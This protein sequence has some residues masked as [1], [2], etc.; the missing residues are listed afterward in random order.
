MAKTHELV[1]KIDGL[2]GKGAKN[3]LSELAKSVTKSTDRLKVLEKVNLQF[4]SLKD[5]RARMTEL[6]S[7]IEKAKERFQSLDR[8]LAASKEKTA[9]YATE[10]KR[11]QEEVDR[12]SLAVAKH[13]R[14]NDE[15]NR[16]LA[17][18]KV[19]LS[20][21]KRNYKESAQE[22]K[23]LSASQDRA[24]SEMG[25]LTDAAAKQ[26]Q[27]LD[28]LE[29]SLQGAGFATNKLGEVQAKVQSKMGRLQKFSALKNDMAAQRQ[30]VMGHAM[31]FMAKA[32]AAKRILGAPIQ[33]AM[34]AEETM[35]GVGKMVDFDSVAEKG[36]FEKAMRKQLSTEIP[37]AFSDYG[38]LIASAAGAG[39]KKDEL[40]AFGS[41]AAKMSIAMDISAGEAGEMMAKWRSAFGMGQEAVVGLADRINYLGDNSA[42]KSAEIAGIVSKVGALGELAGLK[43]SQVA[44][45]GASMVTMGVQSDVAATGIKK[46]STTLTKGAAATKSEQKA[47]DA[48][49]LSAEA[50]AASM[51]QDAAATITDILS[52]VR[53]LDEVAQ[54]SVLTQLFGQ[55]NVQA[56]APLLNQIDLVK[57]KLK[58]VEGSEAMGSL[59][60]E[61]NAR[62]DTTANRFKLFKNQLGNLKVAV[63]HDLLPFLNTLMEKVGG[64]IGKIVAWQ[65]KN[66]ELFSTIVKVTAS[67]IAMSVAMSGLRLMG[68]GLKLLFLPLKAL[69]EGEGLLGIVKS[70]TSIGSKISKVFGAMKAIAAFL[71]ANPYLIAIAAVAA[72][73]Y[74]LVKHWDTVKAAIVSGWNW[75]AQTAKTIGSRIKDAFVHAFQSMAQGIGGILSAIAAKIRSI[76]GGAIS[77][78]SAKI[79]AI[80]SS[81]KGFLGLGAEKK[82]PRTTNLPV[83]AYAR[84]GIVTRPTLGLIGE[85]RSAEAVIP[86]ERNQRSLGLWERTGAALGMSQTSTSS[87]TVTVNFTVHGE[88]KRAELE[89]FLPSLKREVLRAMEEARRDQA[90]RAF[91]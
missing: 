87:S 47:F 51:Q 16:A 81:V 21:L 73:I 11:A 59:E 20:I 83:G 67:L 4:D 6:S 30:Q 54:T 9:G 25:R 66:P 32:Y 29:E 18:A 44:A 74:L 79:S 78:V 61:F 1:F 88:A 56:V 43:A 80:T 26:K 58:S 64:V 68:S 71:A 70:I 45:L 22:T 63:G 55:E 35:A 91:S 53:S 62:K 69:K 23:A 38:E 8:A 15:E 84:G 31:G 41:D 19:E 17:R 2:L 39:I 72:G 13:G 65:Q 42:A 40:L 7:R 89:S 76:I 85:G 57:E 27:K 52:R 46:I 90:R 33:A 12:L 5:G 28:G 3:S 36:A 14:A 34:D 60:K 10:V 37:M 50:V 82:A 86:L 48:L 77:W 49:G 24:R 75:L